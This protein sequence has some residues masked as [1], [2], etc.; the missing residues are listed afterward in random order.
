MTRTAKQSLND[1]YV[2]GLLSGLKSLR[3]MV[4]TGLLGLSL[5]YSCRLMKE[6]D[7]VECWHE[8]LADA[9]AGGY[10]A[11]DYVKVR[12]EGE[13]IEGVDRQY[14]HQGVI[15]GHRLLSSAVVYTDGCDPSL[16]SLKGAVT[17][18]HASDSYPYLNGSE[19]M[20]SVAGDASMTDYDLKGVVVDA[21]FT[22]KLSLRSL[23]Q[24]ELGIIGRFRST[25]KVS[26]Q[27]QSLQARHLAAQFPVGKARYY[28]KLKCYAKRLSVELADVGLIDLVIIWYPQRHKPGWQLCILVSTLKD[29]GVQAL[30]KAFKARW[31]LE[32]SHRTLKQNLALESCQCFSFTAQLRHADFCVA[33]WHHL[34]QLRQMY[35]AL[36]W[37]QAQ[38]L[39]AQIAKNALVTAIHPNS[40]PALAS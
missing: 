30:I 28:R 22:S 32:V 39:A 19:A 16:L 13:K 20:L 37:K 18:V 11:V 26:Y 25:T 5:S 40:P 23:A 15:W 17:Q 34:R 35:P 2:A 4:A 33:A 9:P 1:G 36:S 31:G 7:Q 12:H 3:D 29:H 21:E 24:L 14:S 10:L 38:Q 8:R 6:A 27:G